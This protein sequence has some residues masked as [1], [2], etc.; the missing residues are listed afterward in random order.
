MC[1]FVSTTARENT[2]TY[3]PDVDGLRT[4]AVGGVVLFHAGL[5]ALPGGYVGVDVF[6]VISGYLITR[7]V[8]NGVSRGSFSF[9]EFY[10][11]RARR[12]LPA[13]LLTI[14][15]TLII[16]AIFLSPIRVAEIARSAAA[17]SV[18]L[19]NVWFWQEADYW[20]D[21]SAMQPLLHTWSLSVEEQFYLVW[22]LL[23]FILLRWLPRLTLP[24]LVAGTL[25]SVAITTYYSLHSPDAAFYLT[26]FRTYEFAIGA[27]CV[28]VERIQWG[29]SLIST[30]SRHASWLCGVGLIVA[31]MLTFDEDG[32]TF[33]GWLAL[34]PTVGTALVI[35]SSRPRYLDNVLS[36]RIMLYVGLRSYSIYLVHW[37]VLVFAK[38]FFGELSL[39]AAIACLGV[40]VAIAELQFRLVERPL[41][42]RGP[43]GVEPQPMRTKVKRFATSA[44]PVLGTAIMVCVAS[45]ATAWATSRP[46]AYNIEVRPVMTLDHDAIN[47]DRRLE[48]DSLCK[49]SHT[50][51]L[52]GTVSSS[53]SNVLILG[54]SIA[55]EG[56][57]LAKE[58][59]PEGTNFLIGDKAACPPLLDL[60]ALGQVDLECQ[61]F[62]KSRLRDT[63]QIS[64]EIDTVVLAMRLT[65]ERQKEISDLVSWLDE[66]IPK[67][68]V[69]GMSAHY[70]QAAWRTIA[71][72]DGL[73]AADESLH[74]HLDV[75]S[76]MND[77]LSGSITQAGGLYIDRW[78]WV[79]GDNSCRSHLG[80]DVTNLVMVDG[81]HMTRNGVIAWANSMRENPEVVEAFRIEKE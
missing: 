68:I 66:R 79:C 77:S 16:A 33:P 59:M 45:S 56:Y 24:L 35:L 46:E 53:D 75:S 20:A 7:Q 51:V 43:H 12:L 73:S 32:T 62:N 44:V 9:A 22:P 26:P 67:V 23:I 48:T 4:I 78:N 3:R 80:D 71:E 27:V 58:L 61:D 29:K 39:F 36:N 8:V 42:V 13:A 2:S 41:R 81:A 19:S 25:C 1:W 63:A 37:P 21:S 10:L 17:A 64:S 50:G 76:E 55:P 15:G 6:F 40:T 60:A 14:A 11:R 69:L 47:S 28:W 70:D 18:S 72:S 5:S 34:L 54:D 31:S 57:L 30:I 52:C 65:T 74:E 38:E 49:E